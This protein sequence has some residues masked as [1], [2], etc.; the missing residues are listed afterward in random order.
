LW[1]TVVVAMG[2]GWF[3]NARV[4]RRQYEELRRAL[5]DALNEVN[6]LKYGRRAGGAASK[7]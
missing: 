6:F 1:L 2:V 5:N 3:V 4:E 7:P